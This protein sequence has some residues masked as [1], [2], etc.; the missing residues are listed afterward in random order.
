MTLAETSA[1]LIDDLLKQMKKMQKRIMDLEISLYSCQIN[2]DVQKVK[3]S[4]YHLAFKQMPCGIYLKD[5]DMKYVF[6]MM[7]TLK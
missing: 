6:A 4:Q 5:A 1:K 2:L 7:P 3:T